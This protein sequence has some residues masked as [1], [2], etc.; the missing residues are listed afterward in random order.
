MSEFAF[1]P[2]FVGSMD[3]NGYGE[4]CDVPARASHAN[5]YRSEASCV[6]DRALPNTSRDGAEAPCSA[7][8]AALQPVPDSA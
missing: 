4:R 6:S 2:S 5:S 1:P 8:R 7:R 3:A